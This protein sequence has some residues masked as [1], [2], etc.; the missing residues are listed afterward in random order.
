MK[1][2]LQLQLDRI[3]GKAAAVGT[4]LMVAGGSAF[5]AVPENVTTAMGE[6]LTDVQ[7]LAALGLIIVIAIAAFA[8]MRRAK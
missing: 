5:A 4:S 7:T 1:K 3:N 8:Y 6:A 2:H